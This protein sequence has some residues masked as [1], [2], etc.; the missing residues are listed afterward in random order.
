MSVETAATTDS[1]PPLSAVFWGRPYLLIPHDDG[2]PGY[3][4]EPLDKD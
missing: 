1:K 2:R 3:A 4:C